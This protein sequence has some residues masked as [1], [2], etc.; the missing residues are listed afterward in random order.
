MGL[1]LAEKIIQA[2]LVDG[3]MTPGHE[4]GLK[5]DHTLTQDATGTMAWLEFEAIGLPRVRTERSV[6]YVDHNML[7]TDFRNADDH[8]F[9]Q[10]AAARF[11]AYFSRPGNGICHQVQLERF[12]IP[13]KTLLGS[14]SHTPNSG[15]LG[16]L[17]IGAGG[18]DV[19]V[20][21]GGGA[22][23]TTM[24]TIMGVRL[25]GILQPWV[26][27]KDVILALLQRLTVKGGVGKIIEYFGPGVAS[28]TVDQRATI[29]NMG[30]ELGATT[31]IFPSDEQTQRYLVA[32]GRGHDWRPLAAD[33]GAQYADVIELDL[34]CLEP[35]IAQPSMPDRVMPVREV[36]GLPV[37]QVCIGSCVNSSYEDLMAVATVLKGRQIHRDVSLTIT[38]GSRQVYTMI[39]QNGAL[40]DLIEAGARILESACGPCL[41]MGQAPATG[42]VS[43]RSFNRNFKGRS[44]TA[45][46]QVY[47]ASPE[48]CAAAAL[49]G[50]ITD[51]RELGPYPEIAAPKRYL[52]QDNMIVPPL[53]PEEAAQVEIIRGPNIKP[54]PLG[55]PVADEI[56]GRILLK[57]GDN[58]TTDHIMPAG[59][60]ILPLRS[61]I[62][63]I[64]EYV[65]I[66][67][68]PE[69]VKRARAWGGGIIV[70]GENYGQGSSREH[71]ALAPMYLGVRAV[72][73]RSFSRIHHTNLIN[74]GI[75]PLVFADEA[76]YASVEQGD[77][78]VLSDIH[79]ALREGQGITAH[80]AT[81]G[82]IYALKAQITP[83][84]RE[85]LLAG[86]LLQY[87]RRQMEDGSHAQ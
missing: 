60:H 83:R 23:Y 16:V 59:A 15:G 79:T 51:P 24:P 34:G 57:V 80:N 58:I 87:T 21:M 36:A 33:P 26:T 13:G 17:A 72:L 63:A 70:G 53:P 27:A 44:G 62:P 61:N 35:L 64:A 75:L 66:R 81:K 32:Q 56:T 86:G 5:I 48:T 8:R 28:L 67:V 7:Q 2:H 25:T 18:L 76:D 49:T 39:A 46:D 43:L 78:L 31:S 12:S 50:V 41:G 52:I 6:S 19:A 20:A 84:Q 65:F 10:S 42:T 55:E 30:A 85:I 3:V 68:D 22:F 40:A 38:P 82:L 71:A 45:D 54:I 37:A 11:G 77:T 1:T 74:V 9:L 69:F 47:L 29:C 4:I 73:A 14:D